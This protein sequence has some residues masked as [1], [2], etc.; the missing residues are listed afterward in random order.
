MP[1]GV[2]RTPLKGTGGGGGGNIIILL[3]LLLFLL[4]LFCATSVIGLLAVEMAHY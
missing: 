3:L 1:M 2:L 4:L